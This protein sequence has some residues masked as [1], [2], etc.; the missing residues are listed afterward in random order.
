[1]VAV[2]AALD[3]DE[4]GT[5][6]DRPH[7]VDGGHRRLGARVGEAPQRDAEAAGQ[8][9]GHRDD[10]GRRLGEVGAP[11]DAFGD[12]ANDRR[13]AVSG[14][15]RAEAAVEV[16]VLGA[17]DVPHPRPDAPLEEDGA[18]R[19]VLPRRGDPAGEVLA[20]LDVQLVG[21]P[22]ASDERR[23]LGRD[24]DVEG[25]EVPAVDPGDDCHA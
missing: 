3:L 6:G 13:V 5:V 10:V 1:V 20:R 2:V 17:V 9:G 11:H 22:G 15:H 18:R 4:V 14:Q 12:S 24:Q 16:D 25:V 7:Q 21:S 8:L 23:L 19:G